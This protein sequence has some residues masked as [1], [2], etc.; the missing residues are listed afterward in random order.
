MQCRGIE[1]HASCTR[2]HNLLAV[3]AGRRAFNM[4][5]AKDKQFRLAIDL[6]NLPVT[7]VFNLAFCR[8]PSVVSYMRSHFALLKCFTNKLKTDL[9]TTDIRHLEDDLICVLLSKKVPIRLIGLTTA[10]PI[11]GITDFYAPTFSAI[12][13]IRMS[14]FKN[15]SSETDTFTVIKSS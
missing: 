1:F 6:V 2:S 7:Q 11:Q 8:N 14:A 15:F 5:K 13:K 10:H 9:F 12:N 3:R 4:R